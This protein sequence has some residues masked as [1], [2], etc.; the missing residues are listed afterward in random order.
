MIKQIKEGDFPECLDTIRKSF[1]TVADEF[2]LTPEN[3]PTNGAFMPLTRLENDY[4]KGDKMYGLYEGDNIVGFVQLVKK[5]NGIFELEKLAV[6]PEHRH[7]GYG[8][9][10]IRFSED[11]VSEL[12]GTVIAIG[13]IEENTRLKDWYTQNGFAHT[14]TRAFSHLPFTVGFMEMKLYHRTRE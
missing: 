8:K 12:G 13:I 6:L 3:C 7:K 9:Q 4:K 5:E 11:K 10:L 1:Q 2:G 14:G